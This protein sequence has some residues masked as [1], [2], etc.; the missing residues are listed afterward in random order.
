MVRL[1]KGAYWDTEIKLAQQLGLDYP[2]FTRKARHRRFLSGLRRPAAAGRRSVFPQFATHNVR[3]V[4]SILELAG[5]N[6]DF[7]FQKLHGMGDRLYQR[8]VGA[9]GH[10]PALPRLRAGREATASCCPISCAACS[11]TAPTAPSYT[12]SATAACPWSA[13]SPIP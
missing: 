11:R 2:V 13:W 6:R 8:I 12:R 4:A 7:E 3:T 1:V 9:G 10:E 5:D